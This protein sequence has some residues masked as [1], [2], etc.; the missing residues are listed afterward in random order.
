MRGS[1]L[2]S[3]V[4]LLAAIGIAAYSF[5]A[6]QSETKGNPLNQFSNDGQQIDRIASNATDPRGIQ[7]G[8]LAI[9]FTL[10][11]FSEEK[12]K[13]L[14]DFQGSFVV[15]NMWASWCPPCREEM[16]YL[17]Q[18]YEDYK[19]DNVQVVGLNMTTQERNGEVIAQFIE[20]FQIPFLTMMDERGEVGMG[21][22]IMAIPMTFIL[23]P[24]GRIIKRHQGYI[25]YDMLERFINEAQAQYVKG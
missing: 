17:I 13:S 10:P 1:R 4:I 11:V 7:E 23:D 21:Y 12:T 25:N 8:D 19:D 14:S 22:Q 6:L 3:I 9:N 5:I 20:E 15:L 2:T 24:D 18:F 16:P